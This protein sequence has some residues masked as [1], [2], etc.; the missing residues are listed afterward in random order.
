MP[1][2]NETFLPRGRYAP[3]AH[4]GRNEEEEG[5]LQVALENEASEKVPVAIWDPDVADQN[6]TRYSYLA[7]PLRVTLEEGDMLYLPAMW[8]HKVSQTAGEEGFVCALNYWY[9]MDFSGHFWSGNNFVR[10]VV[11]E[12]GGQGSMGSSVGMSGK[13][14]GE[15]REEK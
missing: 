10:D 13:G 6:T 15:A 12:E 8:Y 7:N 11:G 14:A 9:D 2:V 3:T 4:P 1:C 5:R